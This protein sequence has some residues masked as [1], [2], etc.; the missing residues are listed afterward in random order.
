MSNE[1]TVP[2]LFPR[3]ALAADVVAYAEQ[4]FR[5]RPHEPWC[6]ALSGGADSVALL[7]SLLN[8]W[9]EKRAG[10]TALHFNHRLRGVA[11]DGDE[12][13]CREWC[14]KRGVR[15]RSGQWLDVRFDAGEAEAR[16]ARMAFFAAEMERLGATVLWTGHQLDDI[17]ETM[18]MRVARGSSTAGLAAPRPVQSASGG[19]VFLR[20]LL[21]I[22]KAEILARL[23]ASGVAWRED[24]SNAGG[25]FFR[26]RVRHDVIP[27]WRAAAANDA[28]AGAALTRELLAEDDAALENWLA[29]CM[30]AC[31]YGADT[32]DLRGLAAHPRALWRRALRRWP[33]LAGLARA[34][35]ED[36]LALCS[37][38]SGC[39]SAGDGVVELREGV[40]HFRPRSQADNQATPWGPV[41]LNPGVS[42][43]LPSGSVLTAKSVEF[44][45]ELRAWIRAGVVDPACEAYVSPPA[46]ALVVRSAAA[47]DRY[48]PLGAPG[49]AKLQDLFVNKKI[50]AAH[51]WTLPVI[52]DES[53]AI[54][55]VPG[56]PPAETCKVTDAKVTGLHL[57]YE[58]GTSTVRT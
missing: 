22:S 9:P 24:A 1:A 52:C 20:P 5:T 49:S 29:E 11:S 42:L 27:A 40:L 55:W 34:G 17:A 21:T 51:R 36:V 41:A 26:N 56:L 44:A 16:A 50:P 14:E 6:V 43:F 13:F 25:D 45:P 57:T 48:R 32:L 53:G 4:S 12:H 31:A 38:G 58:S 54:L 10:L 39:V 19:R 30:P 35:F 23:Q 2:S 47:G 18:L 37:R 33:P 28:L 8:H 46:S 3:A 7:C 15:F